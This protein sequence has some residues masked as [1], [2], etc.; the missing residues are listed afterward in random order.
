MF[1]AHR[2]A[3]QPAYAQKTPAGMPL[4]EINGA[5]SSTL[6]ADCGN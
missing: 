2:Q 4:Q 3:G 6:F 5:K 1:F